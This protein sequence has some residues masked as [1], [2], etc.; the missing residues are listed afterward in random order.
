MSDYKSRLQK[1]TVPVIKQIIRQYTSHVKLT[2][3]GK[4]KA[5]LIEHLMKHTKLDNKK[6]V[7]N[8]NLKLDIPESKPVKPKP[9][10][11][12]PKPVKPKPVKP[13]EPK[14]KPVKPKPVK[15]KPESKPEPPTKSEEKSDE[16]VIN[17][18]SSYTQNEP[19]DFVCFNGMSFYLFLEVLIRNKNDCLI[20]N[21]RSGDTEINTN[22]F[23]KYYSHLYGLDLRDLRNYDKMEVF[24][25]K[26]EECAKRNKILV[27][28]LFKAGHA[29]M[30]V[31]NPFLKQIEHYEPHGTSTKPYDIAIKKIAEYFK[32]N[33]NTPYTKDMK[34]SPSSDACPNI[35]KEIRDGWLLAGDRLKKLDSVGLQMLDGTKQQRNQTVVKD[36]VRVRDT[37]GFCCMWSFLQMDFRLKNPKVPTNALGNR[38]IQLAKNNPLEFFRKYIRGYTNDIM[39]RLIKEIGKDDLVKLNRPKKNRGE[40]KRITKIMQD[41]ISKLWVEAGGKLKD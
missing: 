10:K 26:Y 3:K 33:G 8:E 11:P 31:F 2:M 23:S 41:V 37:G 19:V 1:L 17:A 35:S 7:L 18:L 9:V 39:K 15:P 22:S 13:D 5:S 14:P 27:I 34:Y 36:G 40:V 32:N 21:F 12:E 28:P 30:I 29:N 4:N 20:G 25:K 16:E 6:I 38:L 24:L